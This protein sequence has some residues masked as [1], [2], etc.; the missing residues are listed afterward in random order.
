MSIY[1]RAGRDI[2]MKR[3]KMLK[4]KSGSGS[5]GGGTQNGVNLDTGFFGGNDFFSYKT[6]EVTHTTEIVRPAPSVAPPIAAA[7]SAKG[8]GGHVRQISAAAQAAAQAAKDNNVSYSVTISAD[9]PP[10]RDSLDEE[11][12]VAITPVHSHSRPTSPTPATTTATT[13]PGLTF[14]GGTDALTQ[15][16]QQRQ[17]MQARRRH[18]ANSA[19]W[20]YVKCAMLFFSAL[21]VTWIPSSGNRV[22]TLINKG[23]V[24]KPLFF[25]SAF[26]LPLQGFWNAIIYMMTSWAA[27]KSLWATLMLSMPS[28]MTPRN[29]HHRVAIVEIASRNHPS[30]PTR[31]MPTRLHT[32]PSSHVKWSKGG[33]ES[34][35]MEDLTSHGS[36]VGKGGGNGHSHHPTNTS[37]D[38]M[39]RV[40]PV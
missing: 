16:Q 3:K 11:E 32:S 14:P 25:A 36:G 21:L 19:T 17:Q 15:Q 18:E 26:V 9:K 4:F 31:R 8:G 5:G 22:Y 20:P 6:T 24:S 28:W 27:C 35:S 29:R 10:D 2:Y 23:D 1:I 13:V 30:E 33:D 40:S 12:E 37:R 7:S 39:D 34:T 38:T